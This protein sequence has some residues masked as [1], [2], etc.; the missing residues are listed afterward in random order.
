MP[1][2]YT[3]LLV[4][5]FCLLFPF[6]AGFHPRIKFYKQWKYFLLPCI[7]TAIVFIT[8]DI[9]FVQW[10]VWWFNKRYVTGFF[11]FNIPLEEILFFICIPYACVFTYYCFD[12]FIRFPQEGKFAISFHYIFIAILLITGIVFY[13]RLYTGVT[14]LSLAPVLLL[15]VRRPVWNQGAF[16]TAYIFILIPFFISNGI[17]TGC[18]TPEP[19]VLYNNEE[20]LGIRMFTIPVEDAFYAILLM[21]MNVYGFEYLRKNANNKSK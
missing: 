21:A 20:N 3:Y 14:F 7:I 2:K 13:D 10:N 12:K 8:W 15:A 9:L 1:D 18:C 11:F 6:I 16:Y 19:V 5:F 17:L 4:D